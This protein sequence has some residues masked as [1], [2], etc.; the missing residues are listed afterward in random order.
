MHKNIGCKNSESLFQFVPYLKVY[1]NLT[2]CCACITIKIYSEG[3]P[4]HQSGVTKMQ[5]I[6]PLCG[7]DCGSYL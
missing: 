1:E 4:N 6:S 7:P 5:F 2:K 3:A